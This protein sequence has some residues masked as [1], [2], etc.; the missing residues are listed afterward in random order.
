MTRINLIEFSKIITDKSTSLE[1]LCKQSK[2]DNVICCPLCNSKKYYIMARGKLR[3]KKCKTDYKP[4]RNTWLDTINIDITKWRVL[5]KLFD[6]GISTR[7]AAG[8]DDISYPTALNAFDSIRYA[9]LYRL[10][11]TDKKLKGEIETDKAVFWRR[12]K[13]K[14]WTR[15]QKQDNRF[16]DTGKKRKGLS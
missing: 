8:E 4:F 6:L 13:G 10:A 12:K 1:F 14:S 16:W 11:D 9:I 15:C 7:R 3:C 2:T 5:I